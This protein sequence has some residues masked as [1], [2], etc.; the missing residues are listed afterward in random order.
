MET[1]SECVHPHFVSSNVIGKSGEKRLIVTV[2]TK[3]K[4]F[5]L[6]GK[7]A[8]EIKVSSRLPVSRRDDTAFQ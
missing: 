6:L 2:T 4:A 5:L 1:M 3:E 8:Y 7:K